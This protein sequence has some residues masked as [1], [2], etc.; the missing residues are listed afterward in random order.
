[1]EMKR[2][3]VSLILVVIMAMSFIVGYSH[4]FNLPVYADSTTEEWQNVTT[5]EELAEAFRYYCKSRDL[6]IDGS[7]ADGVTKFTTQ[8]F[9]NIVRVLGIDVT[10]LQANLKKS[11]D[12]NGRLQFLFNQSGISTYNR[13]FSQFLQDNNLSVGDTADEQNNT[14]YDGYFYVDDDNNSCLVWDIKD[15]APNPVSMSDFS[16]YV[17][18]RGT[19]YIYTTQQLVD[20]VGLDHTSNYRVE[21]PAMNINSH[22]YV[23]RLWFSLSTS[24]GW[25][26]IA[27]NPTGSTT[28]GTIYYLDNGV[29][30]RVDGYPILYVTNGAVGTLTLGTF[31]LRTNNTF[32]IHNYNTVSSNLSSN[33]RAVIY[34][35]TNNNTINNNT[36]EGDTYTTINEDGQSTSST[37][38]TPP[39]PSGG[40]GDSTTIDFPDFDFNIPDLNWSLG[41]LSQKFPFSIPFDLVAFY[42]LLNA[43]P[44]APAIDANIPLG[45]FYTWRFQADFSQFDNY[46][47]II[48]N[49]EYIGFVVTLIY[50]TIKFVKG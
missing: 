39:P 40:G 49:V 7:I 27:F 14:V 6:T 23:M 3:T 15:T 12:K 22:S 20:Y 37:D 25:K 29:Q 28:R 26:S 31:I 45:G 24:G 47:V 9:N 42:T 4:S 18:K 2:V 41:D 8:T 17:N 38:E 35:T 5:N 30:T 34:L 21:L 1:M 33:D 16:N 48:R 19:N 32:E 46:A 50:I 10:A 36:Y 11:T 44:V 13:I 43:D